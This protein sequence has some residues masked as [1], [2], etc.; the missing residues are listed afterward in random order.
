ME[1]PR[2]LGLARRGIGHDAAHVHLV[3]AEGM[4]VAELAL[5][6]LGAATTPLHLEAAAQ[7]REVPLIPAQEEAL[8][9][10]VADA[11]GDAQL[12]DLHALAFGDLRVQAPPQRHGGRRR[13]IGRHRVHEVGGRRGRRSAW[14]RWGP[15][16]A[17]PRRRRPNR[18]GHA[19]HAAP[20]GAA[21]L[22]S[23]EVR[24][25]E[26]RLR[27]AGNGD[28]ASFHLSQAAGPTSARR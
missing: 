17:Q 21:E 27:V 9:P 19:S 11:R 24:R 1:L 5:R 20:S 4:D 23:A 16:A 2:L 3:F 25:R 6:T 14:H 26:R 10:L 15:V 7:G 22:R 12:V 8:R 28:Y 13:P 18:P